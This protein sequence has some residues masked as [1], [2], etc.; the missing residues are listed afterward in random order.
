MKRTSLLVVVAALMLFGSVNAF[1]CARCGID[2]AGNAICLDRLL[3]GEDCYIP[4]DDY[5]EVV[6]TCTTAA[7]AN[8]TT[9]ASQY[10]VASVERLDEPHAPAGAMKTARLAHKTTR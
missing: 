4:S 1:A 8:Q 9:L 10:A 7:T 3:G 6:G 2:R 5:C